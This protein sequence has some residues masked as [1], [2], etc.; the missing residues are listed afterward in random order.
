MASW[1]LVS[2]EW[3][4]I[5]VPI[6]LRD[7]W[8]T[9]QSLE[10]SFPWPCVQTRRHHRPQTKRAREYRRQCTELAQYAA[11]RTCTLLW[12]PFP[13][14][15]NVIDAFSPNITS[16]HFAL[17]DCLPT[18]WYLAYTSPPPPLLVGAP[19]GT[20][21]PE[22]DLPDIFIFTAVKRLVVREANS[23]FVAF[24]T[25]VC[26]QLEC[27]ESTAEFGAEYLPPEVASKVRD[28][29]VFR[30]LTPTIEWG[31]KGKD[32]RRKEDPPPSPIK[33]KK[34]SFWCIVRRAIRKRA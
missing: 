32:I 10:L 17:V 11:D 29:M 34:L 26:P 28:R 24:F 18:F 1:M 13:L 5:V 4:N 3:L 6:F 2:R 23:D 16:I 27:I 7:I 8:V 9:S 21:Y 22:C 15:A 19:R 33:Q 25:T 12:H 14:P 30:L 31:I 20:F